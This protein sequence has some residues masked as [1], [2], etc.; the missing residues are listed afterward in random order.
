MNESPEP[1]FKLTPEQ[2]AI[3]DKCFHPSGKFIEFSEEDVETSI[4][5]RFEKIAGR[6][7]D[8]L[9]VEVTNRTLTYQELNQAANRL[10]HGILAHQGQRQEPIALFMEHDSPLIAAIVGVLKAGAV[11][12][13]L[14]PSFP[15]ARS[16]FLLEDSQAGL[17][18]TDSKNLSLAIE[19]AQDRCRFV[20][21]DELDSGLSNDNP[22]LSIAPDHFAFLVYTSGSTGQP[23]GVIQNHR[24]LLH[25]SRL[26][27]N[28][29]HIC[30][31]DR[32]A[33]LYSCGVSQGLKITFSTLLNGASLCLFDLRRKGAAD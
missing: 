31:D 20:N 33:L 16:V 24:N 5:E 22:G 29:L 11:C 10:A 9:A 26:Y 25:D 4:P 15:K 6:F 17:L 13:V 14:D 18:I 8:R 12:V 30:T 23:K 32:V 27:C 21:I 7:P 2:Q 1:G 19:Y 28:G 3:W